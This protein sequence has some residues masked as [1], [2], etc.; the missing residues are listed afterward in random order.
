[1]KKFILIPD[2]FKGTLSSLQICGI[3]KSQIDKH[4]SNAEVISI[5]VADG[6]EGIGGTSPSFQRSQTYAQ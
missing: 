2:S 6:G 3:I 5:P 1:M 4:F